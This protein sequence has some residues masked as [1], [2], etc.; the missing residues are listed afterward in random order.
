MTVDSGTDK[1]VFTAFVE[2]V[3]LKHIL[4][5]DIVIMDNLSAHKSARV[6]QL[7]HSAGAE[8][9]FQ[10]PYSPHLNPIEMAWSKLKHLVRSASTTS[11]LEVETAIKESL[12][13][14]D[15]SDA[16][17]WFQACG[18]AWDLSF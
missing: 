3:L 8:L 7:I 10:P 14:L 16:K 12:I 15:Y 13:K 4:P 6:R 2:Q 11:R 1:E 18:Y 17:G 5:D 9:V